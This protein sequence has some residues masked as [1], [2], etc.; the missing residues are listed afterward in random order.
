MVIDN[1]FNAID[2]LFWVRG[3]RQ[4]VHARP[5]RLLSHP[6]ISRRRRSAET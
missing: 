1:M 6:Y 4:Y 5:M 3:R 2:L